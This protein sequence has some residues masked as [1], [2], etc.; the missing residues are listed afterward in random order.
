MP[1]IFTM[2]LNHQISGLEFKAIF[3]LPPQRGYH[4][5][6][7]PLFSFSPIGF[8]LKRHTYRTHT[9]KDGC[10]VHRSSLLIAAGKTKRVPVYPHLEPRATFIRDSVP[11]VCSPSQS[12]HRGSQHIHT[13]S[14]LCSPDSP[15]CWRVTARESATSAALIYTTGYRAISPS[16]QL[17]DFFP[18]ISNHLKCLISQSS[19]CWALKHAQSSSLLKGNYVA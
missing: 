12:C 6:P 4:V 5:V 3:H 16:C 14:S 17:E 15:H 8:F 19:C 7:V 9:H 2:L 1:S 18:V 10:P 13:I 11:A